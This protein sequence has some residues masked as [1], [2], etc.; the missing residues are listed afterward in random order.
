MNSKKFKYTAKFSREISIAKQIDAS[1]VSIDDH[2]FRISKASIEDISPFFPSS[3]NLDENLDLI[4]LFY[5]AAVINHFNKNGQG[6]SSATAVRIKDLCVHKPNNIEHKSKD[7][8]GHTVNAVFTEHGADGN[9]VSDM[10]VLNSLERFD[11]SLSSV[12]YS[13]VDPAFTKLV[14]ESSLETSDLHNKISAS[15][16]I[17]FDEYHIAIGATDELK[18]CVVIKDPE[19]IAKFAKHLKSKGGSGIDEDGNKVHQ[20]I[21]GEATLPVAFAFT[22]NPAGAVKGVKS[23]MF[24]GAAENNLQESVANISQNEKEAVKPINSSNIIHMENDTKL[25]KEVLEKLEALNKKLG[26]QDAKASISEVVRDAIADTNKLYLE[27]INQKEDEA[28]AL[29][30]DKAEASEKIESLEAQLAETSVRLE[31][32]EKLQA[33]QIALATF[34]ERMEKFDAAFT[35]PANALE[36]VSKEIKALSDE[37]FDAYLGK[38]EILLASFSKASIEAVETKRQEEIEEA[39]KQEVAK[40]SAEEAGAEAKEEKSEKTEEE[41]E[42]ALETAKASTEAVN[43]SDAQEETQA[44]K[45]KKAFSGGDKPVFSV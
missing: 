12:I 1:N 28:A 34:S 31:K 11:L 13:T 2:G 35:L 42:A 32:F 19:D 18:D 45:W 25:S 24:H 23:E 39:K 37:D 15:W 36:V 8:V 10:E 4:G 43:T 14:V 17:G 7:I 40:A 38:S 6:I 30:A 44:Q 26:D 16:E 5:D 33:E 22:T 41:I 9:V 27:T 20:L 21:V 29:V 3:V